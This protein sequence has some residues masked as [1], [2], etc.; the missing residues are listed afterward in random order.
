MNTD[1]ATEDIWLATLLSLMMTVDALM[2]TLENVN[3]NLVAE[4][5]QKAARL[6]KRARSACDKAR[7]GVLAMQTE[8]ISR[9]ILH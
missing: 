5:Q 8:L 2:Q 3:D 1:A 4:D 6:M 7:R 9:Q